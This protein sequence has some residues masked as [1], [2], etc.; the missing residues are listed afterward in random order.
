MRSLLEGR[1]SAQ[2]GRLGVKPAPRDSHRIPDLPGRCTTQ[3]CAM[4]GHPL[5]VPVPFL[6][7]VM[8]AGDLE[9]FRSHRVP[10]NEL[11]EQVI[12]NRLACA[13]RRPRTPVGAMAP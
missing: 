3:S 1:A 2:H 13:L 6:G 4:D 9:G 7:M 12:F 10:R 8:T 5:L 11:P